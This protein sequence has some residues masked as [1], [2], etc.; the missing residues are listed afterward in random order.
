MKYRNRRITK[1]R[2]I[3]RVLQ[4][5]KKDPD[6]GRLNCFNGDLMIDRTSLKSRFNEV[7]VRSWQFILATNTRIRQNNLSEN[8]Q[9]VCVQLDENKKQDCKR[10]EGRSSVTEEWQRYSDYRREAD[11]H[12]Y[13]NQQVKKEY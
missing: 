6:Y 13:I 11:G 5:M 12:T 2:E 8:L 10:P 1:C 9:A 7:F 3:V 4:N